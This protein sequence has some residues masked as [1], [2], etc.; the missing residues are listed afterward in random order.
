M[1]DITIPTFILGSMIAWLIGALVHLIAGGR[2]LRLIFCMLFAWIGFW[3]G[4]Y[5]AIRFNLHILNY[6]Q[7]NY[8][9]ALIVCVAASLFGFWLS[10]E[11]RQEE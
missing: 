10:G 3:A 4:N 11:N 1:F 6:G 9:P 5:L 2:L 8:G 7:I